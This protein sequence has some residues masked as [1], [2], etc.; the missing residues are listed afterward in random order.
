MSLCNRVAIFILLRNTHH[1]RDH[2]IFSEKPS[3][4]LGC[5]RYMGEEGRK[6]EM[7]VVVVKVVVLSLCVLFISSSP[8]LT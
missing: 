4:A 3:L 5:E 7:K 8:L 2:V 1:M 6:E